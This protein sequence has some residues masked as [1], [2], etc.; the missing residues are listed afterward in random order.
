MGAT[1][2]S[3][4]LAASFI[5]AIIT[6]VMAIASFGMRARG[7]RLFGYLMIAIA[8]WC[9]GVGG[10]MLSITEQVSGYWLSLM[11][12]GVVLTPPLWMIFAFVYANRGQEL[13]WWQIALTFLNP[14]LVTIFF[15]VPQL[16]F[17]V[18]ENI[19]YQP[20][21]GYLVSVEWI[22]GPY[23]LIHLV[24]S[25]LIVLFGDIVIL[26]HVFQWPK[27]SR[28]SMV[29]VIIASFFPL[30]TNLSLVVNLFPQIHGNI[31]V[32]GF[33][34]MGIMIGIVMYLEKRLELQ[35]IA[36][37]QLMMELPDALLVFDS[38]RQL[39][40]INPAAEKLFDPSI[41]E[42]IKHQFD[43]IL[44]ET[45]LSQ[46]QPVHKRLALPLG[47]EPRYYDVQVSSLQV[48]R[49]VV[50]YQMLLRDVTELIHSMEK[51]EQ[52]ATTDP[53]TGLYNRRYFHLEGER[54]YVQA[55]RYGHPICVLT[56]DLDHFKQINDN[57]G[58][59][60]GDEVLKQVAE[61]VKNNSRAVDIIARFGGDEFF[62][63]LPESTVPYAMALVKRIQTTL[64]D[65]PF[66]VDG[67]QMTVTASFGIASSWPVDTEESL[68]LD[69]LMRVADQ[70]LY[71][72]KKEGGNTVRF[73]SDAD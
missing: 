47:E 48:M 23:F 1:E 69:E 37:G 11:M 42:N 9:F 51:L 3:I 72:A 19:I 26:Q 46:E 25:F 66:E 31:D 13:S 53:L 54:M 61:R 50:G 71:E 52:L 40:E 38:S 33:A 65:A 29:L 63:L 43:L 22:L 16:R 4:F 58:H 8:M 60:A 67:N 27:S 56:F 15:N 73:Y 34:V 28:V 24:T 12:L 64:Q 10:Q 59:P 36:A 17:L 49:Q 39:V 57:F 30:F 41:P 2:Y 68:S 20:L 70:M 14:L 62:V 7:A 5:M 35:P 18:V 44:E 6:F 21:N 32:F 55:A 45:A